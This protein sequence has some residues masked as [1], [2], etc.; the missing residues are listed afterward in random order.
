MDI[1][2]QER[3]A[4]RQPAITDGVAHDVACFLYP[5]AAESEV[6]AHA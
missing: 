3:P 4:M 2:A 5:S 6:L 1:C